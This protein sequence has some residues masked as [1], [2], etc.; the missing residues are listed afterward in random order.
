MATITAITSSG[1]PLNVLDPNTWIG[2]V[3]PGP[4]DTAVFPHHPYQQRPYIINNTD[5]Q[6]DTNQ[7]MHPWPEEEDGN[8]EMRLYGNTGFPTVSG[9]VLVRLFPT[10]DK[11]YIKIDYDYL[12]GAGTST[13]LRNLR[14]DRTTNNDF[15]APDWFFGTGS[16]E[17][18]NSLFGY[19][20][21][22]IEHAIPYSS[23]AAE[24]GQS[25]PM[26]YELTGSGVW[27]VGKVHMGDHNTFTIK[28]Q[29]K[30]QLCDSSFPAIDFHTPIV[31]FSSLSITDEATI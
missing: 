6:G 26:M 18:P 23:S 22:N 4:S 27:S 29:S 3:V 1:T 31:R 16:L 8:Y 19:I 17:N 7:F 15:I 21:H 2:G 5:W 11:K 10:P 20:Q 28:D 12:T 13:R 9:S 14:I 24:G 30:I 25:G